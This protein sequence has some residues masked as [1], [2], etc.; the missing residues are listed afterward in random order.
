MSNYSTPLTRMLDKVAAEREE[1]QATKPVFPPGFSF[2]T[3]DKASLL[4]E[5][6]WES[7][8]DGE[9]DDDTELAWE[10][11]SDCSVCDGSCDPDTYGWMLN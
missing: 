11:C 5:L 7:D 4:L 8:E 6:G 10:G 3:P 1:A 9:D 2:D